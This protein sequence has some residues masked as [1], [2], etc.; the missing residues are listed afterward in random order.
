MAGNNR[1]KIPYL[2][3]IILLGMIDR[4]PIDVQ[5]RLIAD[6]DALF[7]DPMHPTYYMDQFISIH[8]AEP[9]FIIH[10]KVRNLDCDIFIIHII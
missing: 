9:H 8:V 3:E 7:A 1:L 10:F 2:A 6:I 5:M 4:K